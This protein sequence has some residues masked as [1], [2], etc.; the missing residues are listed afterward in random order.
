MQE[1]KQE[2]RKEQS[3][4]V[5]TEAT[6]N[7][8]IDAART[9]FATKGYAD[10]GTPEIVSAAGVTRG[11]LYHHFADKCELFRAVV[12]REAET[13]AQRISLES[14][15]PE[16]SLE[17]ILSGADAYFDAMSEAGRARLLLLEG[18]AILGVQAMEELD[19]RTG[20]AELRQGLQSAVQSAGVK[21][22]LD[23]LTAVFSAAFDRAALGIVLGGSSEDYRQ[24]IRILAEGIPGMKAA[25]E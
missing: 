23:A 20:Q 1:M 14:V 19:R 6:R 16:S 7:A 5:R 18:P 12:E 25:S 4:R 11:A 13:V 15:A 2:S 17:G 8:L 10:T 22:P 24:A 3:N 9:L 21:V